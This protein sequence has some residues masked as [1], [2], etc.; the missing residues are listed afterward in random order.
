MK[1]Y[2]EKSKVRHGSAARE[3]PLTKDGEIAVG[4]FVDCERPDYIASMRGRL[5]SSWR[6]LRRNGRTGMRVTEIRIAGFGARV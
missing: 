2:K 6:A 1:Y 5:A 3:A 4:K